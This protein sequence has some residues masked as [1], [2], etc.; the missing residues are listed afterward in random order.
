MLYPI[1]EPQGTWGR[2]PRPDKSY[3]GCKGCLPMAPPARATASVPISSVSLEEFIK[4]DHV[5][6]KSLILGLRTPRYLYQ[7][8]GAFSVSMEG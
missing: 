8:L 1:Q 4:V 3:E 2:R 7:Y 6:C 5:G